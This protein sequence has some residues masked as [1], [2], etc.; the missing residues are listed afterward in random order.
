M[1]ILKNGLERHSS[2]TFLLLKCGEILFKSKGFIII[3][4][5]QRQVEINGKIKQIS[6]NDIERLKDKCGI[7][8][9]DMINST[10]VEL[11]IKRYTNID[12]ILN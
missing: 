9:N 12:I 8:K 5:G 7:T 2:Y 10:L 3:S 1:D 11:K 4:V 6:K